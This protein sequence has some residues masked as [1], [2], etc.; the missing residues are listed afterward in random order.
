MCFPRTVP[1]IIFRF[2]PNLIFSADLRENKNNLE[3]F[4]NIRPVRAELSFRTE[5]QSDTLYETW[6][7]HLRK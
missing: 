3:L 7:R 2:P 4:N 1:V 6:Q 5:G